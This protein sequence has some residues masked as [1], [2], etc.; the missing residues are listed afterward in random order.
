MTCLQGGMR[1]LRAW[2]HRL[3]IRDRSENQDY[4]ASSL[5]VLKQN[6]RLIAVREFLCFLLTRKHCDELTSATS[7]I[8]ESHFGHE[9]SLAGGVLCFE[10]YII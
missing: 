7:T 9:S 3:R 4:V 6:S 5:W 10:D 2:F 8:R 1:D